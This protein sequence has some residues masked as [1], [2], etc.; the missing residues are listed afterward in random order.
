MLLLDCHYDPY[1]GCVSVVQVVDGAVTVVGW[2]SLTAS[3]PVLKA[4]M[5]SAL[6]ARI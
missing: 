2:C 3:K 1:R 4:P 5:V 6:E